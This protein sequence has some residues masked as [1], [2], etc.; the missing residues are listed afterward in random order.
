MDEAENDF[1]DVSHKNLPVEDQN[2]QRP[3]TNQ[4]QRI[5]CQENTNGRS[6]HETSHAENRTATIN[7][8]P[9]SDF[10]RFP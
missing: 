5:K 10:R 8:P 2:Q 6:R 4:R 7:P 3:K 9:K 1:C